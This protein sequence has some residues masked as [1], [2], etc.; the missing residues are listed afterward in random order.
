MQENDNLSANDTN[1]HH[2]FNAAACLL[3][4][5]RREAQPGSRRFLQ[6]A[7]LNSAS[8]PAPTL[9]AV[10]A[11]DSNYISGLARARARR[12]N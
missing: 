9:G 12:I 4:R 11:G 7:Q 1:H 3:R 6:C 10:S 5:A 8:R 2:H